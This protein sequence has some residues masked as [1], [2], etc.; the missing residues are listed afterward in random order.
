MSHGNQTKI[1]HPQAV[2]ELAFLPEMARQW[3]LT[4]KAGTE[5]G[6]PAETRVVTGLD[7]LAGA[8]ALEGVTVT[9]YS[10]CMMANFEEE[11]SPFAEL[12]VV[13]YND[14]FGRNYTPATWKKEN[15]NELS[16]HIL[17]T[18]KRDSKSV[19]RKFGVDELRIV[20]FLEDYPELVYEVFGHLHPLD[21]YHMSLASKHLRALVGSENSRSLWCLSYERHRPTAPCPRDMHPLKWANLLFGR[22][23]CQ[24]YRIVSTCIVS[25][26]SF[27]GADYV[28]VVKVCCASHEIV[29][30]PSIVDTMVQVRLQGGEPFYDPNAFDDVQKLADE[31]GSWQH[32]STYDPT[33][34]E[35][36]LSQL[37]S[38]P[39]TKDI[40]ASLYAAPPTYWTW[41]VSVQDELQAERVSKEAF[42]IKM[43]AILTNRYA[44][45]ACLSFDFYSV[46]RHLVRFGRRPL[47]IQAF[48]ERMQTKVILLHRIPMKEELKILK[49]YIRH[50]VYLRTFTLMLYSHLSA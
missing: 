28:F 36:R 45:I 33:M 32:Q 26:S 50:R 30:G 1:L 12:D 16:I 2:K 40:V 25:L 8:E 48:F 46:S 49:R 4:T 44:S 29:H 18:M 22:F 5:V 24:Q 34:A 41:R 31:L 15:L 6:P 39:A 47:D 35:S 19:R 27:G 7:V 21:L 42:V 20:Q 10:S 37:K 23:K 9:E 3:S 17:H 38:D 13:G 43:S 14:A 11:A